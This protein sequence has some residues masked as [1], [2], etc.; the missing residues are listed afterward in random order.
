MR[1]PKLGPQICCIS[2]KCSISDNEFQ[3]MWPH[4][5]F[6]LNRGIKMQLFICDHI[7]GLGLKVAL[8]STTRFIY[9][10]VRLKRV[11]SALLSS[12]SITTYFHKPSNR[13]IHKRLSTQ[14][15]GNFASDIR[16]LK[17]RFSNFN[18]APLFK[19][20]RVRSLRALCRHTVSSHP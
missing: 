6:P 7:F 8:P 17:F 3:S 20:N 2:T 14:L 19:S 4:A 13:I 5:P 10:Y 9:M 1:D 11:L 16:H 15:P 18:K 12:S